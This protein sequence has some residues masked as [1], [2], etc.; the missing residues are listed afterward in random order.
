MYINIKISFPFIP[1]NPP[2]FSI[3]KQLAS[4]PLSLHSWKQ[5]LESNRGPRSQHG[6]LSSPP[7]ATPSSSPPCYVSSGR[8]RSCRAL[9]PYGETSMKSTPEAHTL[10]WWL[11]TQP[12]RRHYFHP[13]LLSPARTYP[14]STFQVTWA[15]SWFD[16]GHVHGWSVGELYRRWRASWFYREEISYRDDKGCKCHLRHVGTA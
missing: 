8:R 2:I 3:S 11:P 1:S 4:L 14:S 6:Q 16:A 10:D 7:F 15:S 13:E 5:Q 12:R 9:I